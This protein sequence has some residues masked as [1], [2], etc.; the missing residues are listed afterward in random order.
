LLSGRFFA[1]RLLLGH[2]GLYVWPIR[3]SGEATDYVWVFNYL[4]EIEGV[5]KKYAV[6]EWV[7]SKFEIFLKYYGLQFFRLFTGSYVK[8]IRQWCFRVDYYEVRDP[9]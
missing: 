9:F 6:Y 4:W 5:F 3:R 1:K 7:V 8:D 2:S